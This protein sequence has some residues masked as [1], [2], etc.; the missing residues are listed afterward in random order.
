M[1]SVIS[2]T[3][4]LD[5]PIS[6]EPKQAVSDGPEVRHVALLGD[7]YIGMKPTM[8]VAEG[9]RVK[10]GQ[11]VFTDKKTLCAVHSAGGWHGQSDQPW[12]QTQ[13]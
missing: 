3:H 2:I 11:V 1:T 7:D 5:L 4:G 9:D 6:G 13:V 10:L 8:V 12:C